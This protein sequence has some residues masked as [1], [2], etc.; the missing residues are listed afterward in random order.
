MCMPFIP[1]FPGANA[2]SPQIFHAGP[3]RHPKDP[4]RANVGLRTRHSAPHPDSAGPPRPCG[5]CLSKP[6]ERGQGDGTPEQGHL[7]H[8]ARIP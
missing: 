1:F 8:G 7:T 3:Y 5:T 2:Y 6:P 4:K